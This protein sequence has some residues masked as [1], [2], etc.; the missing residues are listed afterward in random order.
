MISNAGISGAVYPASSGYISGEE[1]KSR[2]VT[3][4]SAKIKI[5][6]FFPP[7]NHYNFQVDYCQAV[8]ILQQLAVFLIQ[9]SFQRL[10]PMLHMYRQQ[11]TSNTYRKQHTMETPMVLEAKLSLAMDCMLPMDCTQIM[12]C[13]QAMVFWEQRLD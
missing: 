12:N 5:N 13:M 10:I 1:S 9:E 4:I 8:D 3:Q 7:K 2:R 11:H 6:Q